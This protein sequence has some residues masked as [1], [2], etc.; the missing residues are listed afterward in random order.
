MLK[1]KEERVLL[2]NK[3]CVRVALKME[4][5]LPA[6][7]LSKYSISVMNYEEKLKEISVQMTAYAE[8]KL[9]NKWE[10]IER[11]KDTLVHCKEDRESGLIYCRGESVVNASVEE[12]ERFLMDVDNMKILN[13]MLNFSKVM[14]T[15]SDTIQIIYAVTNRIL[16]V[17]PREVLALQGVVREKGRVSNHL[18]LFCLHFH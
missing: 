7:L 17:K 2:T 10:E 15:I 13:P 6:E 12:L 9:E 16:I 4:L 8:L 14:R 3:L 1:V 11:S 18:F 5:N